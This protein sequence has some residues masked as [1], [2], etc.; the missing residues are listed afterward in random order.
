M[1]HTVAIKHTLFNKR[2]VV[3]RVSQCYTKLKYNKL[4]PWLT[5]ME[6]PKIV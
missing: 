3:S 2:E 6:Y 4:L 1:R 5:L